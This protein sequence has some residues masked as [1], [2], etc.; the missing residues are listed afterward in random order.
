MRS[1]EHNVSLKVRVAAGLAVALAVLI[2][3]SIAI[4]TRDAGYTA[5]ARVLIAP[6]PGPNAVAASDT[7]SRGTVV[8]TFAEA[9]GSRAQVDA[10]FEAA[11]IAPEER[12]RVTIE[13]R[14][15]AGA[16]AV[17]IEARAD[18]RALAEAAAS[19]VAVAQPDLQGYSEAFAVRTLETAEGSAERNG[20]SPALLWLMLV[21]VAV[22]AGVV[23]AIVLAPLATRRLGA[24]NSGSRPIPRR[25]VGGEHMARVAPRRR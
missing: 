11:G 20:A 25:A 12:E 10:S 8:G 22:A 3:G 17:I 18:D 4:G 2:A 5:A 14:P 1:K 9:F 13:S 6:V 24:T 23:V 19:A 21:L 16:S 7:L 15:L